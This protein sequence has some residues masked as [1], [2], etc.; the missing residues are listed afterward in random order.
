MHA[1]QEVGECG[2]EGGAGGGEV[3]HDV[4][5]AALR[6]SDVGGIV[7]AAV[8]GCEVRKARGVGGVSGMAG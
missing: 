1:R 6:S 5:G 8:V 3:L 2:A 4:E 7:F